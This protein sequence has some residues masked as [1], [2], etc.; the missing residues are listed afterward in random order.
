M[1]ES[2]SV[3]GA[4]AEREVAYALERAGWSVFLPMFGHHGRIDLLAVRR[5]EVM[6]VQCKTSRVCDGVI[7]FRACSNTANKPKSYRGE[8]DVFGVYA[9]GL[10]R[11]YLVPVNEANERVCTLRL[12]PTANGQQK[13]VRYAADYELRRRC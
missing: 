10:D 13:G 6:R 11:V 5:T 12:T 7:L 3:V 1:D 4:R 9:P 2:P 8:I